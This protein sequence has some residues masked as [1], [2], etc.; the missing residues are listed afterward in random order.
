MSTSLSQ[1]TVIVFGIHIAFSGVFLIVHA[2]QLASPCLQRAKRI[3]QIFS[4]LA[5]LATFTHFLAVFF[6]PTYEVFA[7]TI[8]QL[9][10][11]LGLALASVLYALVFGVQH[12]VLKARGSEGTIEIS[13]R[14][15]WVSALLWGL[16]ME[17]TV[18]I[19]VVTDRFYFYLLIYPLIAS[20]CTYYGA[21][22]TIL[23]RL[24][25]RDV[26][27]SLSSFQEKRILA[28]EK[29]LDCLHAVLRKIKYIKYTLVS[30]CTIITVTCILE[31]VFRI[32]NGE[33][34]ASNRQ[35]FEDA[36]GIQFDLFPEI[37]FFA[38]YP[39]LIT[40]LYYSWTP[41]RPFKPAATESS[42]S[43]PNT[44][45]VVRRRLSANRTSIKMSLK[46]SSKVILAQGKGT[47][48]TMETLSRIIDQK[49]QVG[50][51]CFSSSSNARNLSK[52][53][54]ESMPQVVSPNSSRNQH[55]QLVP[56]D[57]AVREE[58]TPVCLA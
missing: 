2:L 1:E 9:F 52:K 6:I 36:G 48:D 3:I 18:A 31:L 43:D 33:A 27:E 42:D 32:V 40:F 44:A 51:N 4:G 47:G 50:Q 24:L 58:E 55:R 46:A 30:L 56:E 5:T 10:V 35:R 16:A 20:I 11:T 34:T 37:V 26:N 57:Y 53:F 14:G 45:A 12:T 15:A 49:E 25:E 8:V 22:I 7:L 13:S 29:I 21:H 28:G 39:L 17:A 41:M 38:L 23:L 19:S 54:S